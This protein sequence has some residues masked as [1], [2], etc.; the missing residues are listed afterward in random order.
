MTTSHSCFS[1]KLGSADST[2]FLVHLSRSRTF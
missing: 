1:G 2:S